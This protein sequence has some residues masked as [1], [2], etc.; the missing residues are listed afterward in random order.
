MNTQHGDAQDENSYRLYLCYHEGSCS[1]RPLRWCKRGHDEHYCFFCDVCGTHYSRN[2]QPRAM[3][4]AQGATRA[5]ARA[6]AV[7]LDHALAA[8]RKSEAS[9]RPVVVEQLR[10][11][12]PWRA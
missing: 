6:E 11:E 2:G 7:A 5:K 3:L 9:W 4:W 10:Q 1:G 12:R 8:I